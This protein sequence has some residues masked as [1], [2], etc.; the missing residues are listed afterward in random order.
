MYGPSAKRVGRKSNRKKRG[1]VTYCT[2]REY[3]ADKIF[4]Y[5]ISL[6]GE[7]G[8]HLNSKVEQVHL[9]DACQKN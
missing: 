9:T 5:Y 2:D 1:S 3:E 6:I 4:T 7:K 8:K